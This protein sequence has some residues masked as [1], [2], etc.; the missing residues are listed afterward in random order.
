VRK[1]PYTKIPRPH[2]PHD[3][4]PEGRMVV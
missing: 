1:Y 3:E 2:W 4:L